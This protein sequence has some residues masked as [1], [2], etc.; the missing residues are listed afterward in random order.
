LCNFL[1]VKLAA[2]FPALSAFCWIVLTKISAN[3]KDDGSSLRS[4][5][6][7]GP[8][9]KYFSHIIIDVNATMHFSMPMTTIPPPTQE[10]IPPPAPT[11]FDESPPPAA[12]K[13]HHESNGGSDAANETKHTQNGC[14]N[15]CGDCFSNTVQEPINA[16]FTNLI[17]PHRTTNPAE[18]KVE[19]TLS[20]KA[21]NVT[22]MVSL[23]DKNISLPTVCS[24]ASTLTSQS[25]QA[26]NEDTPSKDEIGRR[27]TPDERKAALDN[28]RSLRLKIS[29][30]EENFAK[31]HG[32]TPSSSTDKAPL[33]D[34]YTQYREG[35]RLIRT[36]AACR[37]QAACRGAI[38]RMRATKK[39]TEA[40]VD[41]LLE[42]AELE[43][44][45]LLT[46]EMI[47]K[48][49]TPEER[50]KIATKV[51]S[52][53]LY[54]QKD[55][56]SLALPE[57][58]K[59]DEY[60][61]K[62]CEMPKLSN[63]DGEIL[64][65]CAVCPALNKKIVQKKKDEKKSAQLMEM[66]KKKLAY[67]KEKLQQMKQQMEDERKKVAAKEKAD[68]AEG[69]SENFEEKKAALLGS[70]SAYT[71]G[72][73]NRS[74]SSGSMLHEPLEV[75]AK[76]RLEEMKAAKVSSDKASADD[77]KEY[78]FGQDS[79]SN[80]INNLKADLKSV[81][82]ATT[83]H[84][85]TTGPDV[86]VAEAEDKKKEEKDEDDDLLDDP[87]ITHMQRKIRG[88]PSPHPS[89]GATAPEDYVSKHRHGKNDKVDD[90]KSY[91]G[92]ANKAEYDKFQETFVEFERD[93]ADIIEYM[94]KKVGRRG[95]GNKS[96][97]RARSSSVPSFSSEDSLEFERRRRKERSLHHDKRRGHRHHEDYR[98]RRGGRRHER[99]HRYY[100]QD[101]DSDSMSSEFSYP[102][103]ERRQYY[104]SRPR[105]HHYDE[106]DRYHRG[107]DH[108]RRYAR[109]RDC[110]GR[111]YRDDYDYESRRRGY[112]RP[113]DHREHR[114]DD[115]EYESRRRGK[116]RGHDYHDYSSYSSDSG[117]CFPDI[118]LRVNRS[119][120]D[121]HAKEER[122]PKPKTVTKPL[123]FS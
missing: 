119:R 43:D 31:E 110:R 71:G 7:V 9:Q 35:K 64:D 42:N 1:Q 41:E 33:V 61:C 115:Y 88:C 116:Q 75:R 14:P 44:A 85:N 108:D 36:D 2:A 25:S 111:N 107:Y 48:Y 16:F 103:Y 22:P 10:D 30:Y 68:K 52:E 78:G 81:D 84:K 105:R 113:R 38:V 59:G 50:K 11:P 40:R 49:L 83:T 97:R 66:E 82:S 13:L 77:K 90:D 57:D 89:E 99:G 6:K 58:A 24:F 102:D 3:K 101:Y 63:K 8:F 29:T 92:F 46:T 72:S 47:A 121:C 17:F 70:A 5:Q 12:N 56:L 112:P 45:S 18:D 27:L 23:L 80:I 104:S 34:I 93:H 39:S 114:R 69:A 28:C 109:P 37:I 117:E 91:G 15:S 100:D 19:A 32:R 60:M 62:V 86:I 74:I 65:E 51:L 54:H 122:M 98:H 120:R 94:R 87:E 21:V 4:R 67:E 55:E 118:D 76:K 26:S 106:H 20:L 53:K 79:F 96:I 95:R 73:A 123:G